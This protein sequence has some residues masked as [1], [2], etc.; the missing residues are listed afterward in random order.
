MNHVAFQYDMMMH[1][2]TFQYNK[3]QGKEPVINLHGIVFSTFIDNTEPNNNCN[4]WWQQK[5]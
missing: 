4:M 3:N 2:K 1:M 5:S